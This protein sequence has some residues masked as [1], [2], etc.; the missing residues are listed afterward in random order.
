MIAIRT[1]REIDLLRK[2]N[3]IVAEVLATLA[4][5]VEPGITTQELDA[6]AEEMIRAGGGEPSFLGFQG[7]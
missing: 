6:M 4:D 1:S 3:A 7:L 5:H 2:A